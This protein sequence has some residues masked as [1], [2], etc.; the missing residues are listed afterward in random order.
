MTRER[1]RKPPWIRLPRA[2]GASL[3]KV[4]ATLRSQGLSTVCEEARCPNRAECWGCGTATFLIM[5]RQC[6]R[7]CR[8]CSVRPGREG[9]PLEVDEPTRVAEAVATLELR[10]AVITS[11]SR[12]DLPDG[13]AAHYARTIEAIRRRCPEVGVEVLIPDYLGDDLSTVVGAGPD[14]LAHNLEVVRE[15]TVQVRDRR[16]SYDRSLQVLG[17]ARRLRPLATML[18]K[19]SLLLGMGETDRQIEESLDDLRR[20]EVDMVCLGQYL[21]PSSKHLPVRRYLKPERFVELAEL[22]RSK[23]FSHVA[24]G[25]LVRTSY[26]AAELFQKEPRA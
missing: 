1:L 23:G 17:Q 26:R 14:V 9:E 12:D 8:F 2:E 25:P 21:Q 16:T 4:R 11:V 20:A 10:F 3:G 15:L 18:T 22:A 7:S 13:G 19:S 24:S 6:T 5:G